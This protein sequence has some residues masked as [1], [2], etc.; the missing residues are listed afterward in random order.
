MLLTIRHISHYQFDSPVSYAVQRLHMRPPSLPGQ[1]L[2][3]WQLTVNGAVPDLAYIDWYGNHTDLVRHAP[4]TQN[5]TIIA[6]GQVEVEN[7][8]GVLGTIYGYAPL[9][10][11]ER[12]T[13][14]TM[15]GEG[16]RAL[17]ADMPVN[18][19]RISLLHTLLNT[20]H[21]RVAYVP[22]ATTV[23]TDAETALSLQQGVCQDHTHIFITTARLLG[24]PA[25][26]V[27]GYLMMEGIE[28]QTASHAWAEA[29]VD[30]IGWVGFDAANNI[31][32]NEN[33]VRL[34]CGLDY[35]DAAPVSGIRLGT[36]QESL[37][38]HINVEQ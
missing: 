27:S 13:P 4:N 12:E 16:L 36:A 21:Q 1:T 32:P 2:K 34:A 8:A 35:R 28:Q 20:I 14:L 38:V 37:D 24:I 33:Y 30:G 26:Y 18:T 29:H 6:E 7:R 10:L 15:A 11:F 17:A 19:D 25:R 23:S 3:N 5:I 9:W 22:G 31:C